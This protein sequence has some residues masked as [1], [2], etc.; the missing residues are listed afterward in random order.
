MGHIGEGDRAA[1]ARGDLLQDV[2]RVQR[3]FPG[4]LPR[5][6]RCSIEFPPD[7]R[8][9]S[10][11]SPRH[12]SRRT[13]RRSPRR[14]MAYG[15]AVPADLPDLGLL[16]DLA[17]ADARSGALIRSALRGVDL[18]ASE[19][20]VTSVLADSD[21]LTPSMVAAR[22]GLPRS[23]MTT[24]IAGLERRGLLARSSAADRRSAHLWLTAAGRVVH[25]QA[26]AA[27][28]ARWWPVRDRLDLAETRRLVRRFV[29][30][31]DRELEA[32]PPTD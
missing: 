15:G 1:V 32:E 24:L 28:I 22:I 25:D 21:G 31:V 23:T 11:P 18:T 9:D 27:V 2:V 16:F 7:A 20:A 8:H 6:H 12:Q 14:S 17:M 13:R 4:G 29:T 26:V 10:K 3:P 30:E 19:Y 5:C